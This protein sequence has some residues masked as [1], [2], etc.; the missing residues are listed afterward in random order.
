MLARPDLS[1]ACGSGI[2][3]LIQFSVQHY[4]APAQFCNI[5]QS[6]YSGL[7]GIIISSSWSTPTI[8]LEVGVY[9]GNSLSVIIFNTVIN[10][11][12]DS[13]HTQPDLGFSVSNSHQV[14]ILQYADDTCI[15]AN[16]PAAWQ[17]LLDMVDS[18]LQWSGMRAKFPKCHCLALQSSTG[19][20]LDPCLSIQNQTIPFIGSGSIK[21]LGMTIQ[22]PANQSETKI[23]LK[24]N[25]ERM[26]KAVVAAAELFPINL[27]A[28]N[29]HCYGISDWAKQ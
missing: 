15:T 25:L 21:F 9:Q 5:L 10:T 1:N 26:L 22:V 2:N 29:F 3:S 7:L 20:L 23:A 12:V 11:L 8:P 16:S 19:K 6:L 28:A 27:I 24:T 4:H 14:N 18:W 13:L 17:H